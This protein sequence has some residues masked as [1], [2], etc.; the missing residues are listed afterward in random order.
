M[1]SLFVLHSTAFKNTNL[2]RTKKK[3][4][5]TLVTSQNRPGGGGA[6][7]GGML[8]KFRRT[9]QTKQFSQNGI[10]KAALR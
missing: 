3:S 2:S 8:Y 6:E 7:Q 1:V 5:A 10:K 9:Q 4:R